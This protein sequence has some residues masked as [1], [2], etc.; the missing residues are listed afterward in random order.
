MEEACRWEVLPL[1]VPLAKHPK[2][3]QC[4]LVVWL[5]RDVRVKVRPVA[6]S[7]LAE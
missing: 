7:L 2:A 6:V 3:A 1:Q 5:F 4:R